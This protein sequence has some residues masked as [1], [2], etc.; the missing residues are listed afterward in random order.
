MLIFL[1][2]KAFR[3]GNFGSNCKDYL[4]KLVFTSSV[5]YFDTE[6]SIFDSFCDDGELLIVGKRLIPDTIPT[7]TPTDTGDAD[8]DKNDSNIKLILAISIPA[9]IVVVSI[10]AFITYL[11]IR[12]IRRVS[13]IDE[14]TDNTSL[15]SD[16]V[17]QKYTEV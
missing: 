11:V 10:G 4:S 3:L 8:G 6:K 1:Y 14:N 5:P 15:I 2:Q 9:A 7:M 12:K 13:E 17:H 16:L